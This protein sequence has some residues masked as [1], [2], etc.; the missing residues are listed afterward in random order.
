MAE[1]RRRDWSRPADVTDILPAV[2][3]MDVEDPDDVEPEDAE[4]DDVEPED[5]ELEDAEADGSAVGDPTET[6][7]TEPTPTRAARIAARLKKVLEPRALRLSASVAAGLLMCLSF[8]PF[9]WWYLS[10]F[11]FALLAWVFTHPATRPA[12]GF[13]YGF[14]FGLAF[15]VPLLPWISGL[16]G[17]APWLALSTM[18]ALFPAVFGL[19]AIAVRRL[20]GWPLWLAGVW[21]LAEW[22]KSTV[23]FGGFPWGVVGYSQSDSP[24]LPIA[25][26]GGAPLVSFAVVLV[27]FS[28]TAIVAEC[29]QWWRHHPHVHAPPPAVVV[30]GVCV[31]V[32][33]LAVALSGPYVRQ[34]G[35][36]AGDDPPVTVAAVQ[37]NVP[38]LGLEFNAQ[39]RAVLDYHVRETMRLTEDI[40]AGRA[41]QPAVVIWPENSSDIDPIRN[42]D[43]AELI[44]AAAAAVHAPIL[45]GAVLAAPG[46]SPDNPVSTNSV[47]VWDGATGPGER[48]DKQI[49]QPFGEYLPWRS[50]FRHLS[51]YADRAGYFVPGTGTGVVNAGG[52]PI[53][54]TTCWEV[55]FDRAARESV[56]N[57]AQLLTVPTNNA[58]FDESMSAQQLS[59]ARLRAVEH[60]RY[61]VVAATTGISAVIAP[62]GHEL[63]RTGFFEPAYLDNQVK[64]KSGLTPATRWGPI[65]QGLLVAIGV[66]SVVAGMLHNGGFVRRRKK[67]TETT[68]ATKE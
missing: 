27:G 60:D 68:A 47:I 7:S 56:L 35:L 17:A 55:I 10:F 50:F 58:T 51:S 63:A 13:G 32:V 54:V 15:Y 3:D 64:L 12:G 14:L 11:C 44:S 23:P 22:L 45:V 21:A 59:F 34:S 48:H 19:M 33:L 49:V 46:Y 29:V 57:G 20:P 28:V 66:A 39:R 25:H 62:D 53:G 31:V 26:F 40:R 41:P 38:R 1:R 30:P 16:V 67:A 24:L 42:R 52:I 43:A 5:A 2:H 4:I 8:P 6:P 36:G 9:G 18:E 61:V 65:V 37:G